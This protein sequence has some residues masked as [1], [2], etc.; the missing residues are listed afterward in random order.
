MRSATSFSERRDTREA[1]RGSLRARPTRSQRR[2]GTLRSPCHSVEE[3][4]AARTTAALPAR[5]AGPPGAIADVGCELHVDGRVRRQ[6]ACPPGD[7]RVG[8]F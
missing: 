1:V 5:R 4:E 2:L 3:G 6:G 8:Q 7:L